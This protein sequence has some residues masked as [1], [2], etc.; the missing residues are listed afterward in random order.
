MR[1]LRSCCKFQSSLYRNQELHLLR[2]L[3]NLLDFVQGVVVCADSGIVDCRESHYHGVPDAALHS[4]IRLIIRL[5][6]LQTGCMVAVPTSM[7]DSWSLTCMAC[8]LMLRVATPCNTDQSILHRQWAPASVNADSDHIQ[9]MHRAECD[10][11]M[12]FCQKAHS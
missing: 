1:I 6:I 3:S 9:D 8:G 5:V 11:V 4:H 10:G 7:I 12:L 2:A